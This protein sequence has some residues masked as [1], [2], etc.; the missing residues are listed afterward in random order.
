MQASFAPGRRCA[1]CR[2]CSQDTL[3]LATAF[4]QAAAVREFLDGMERRTR[5]E[6]VCGELLIFGENSNSPDTR[7]RLTP[8]DSGIR[9]LG[10]EFAGKLRSLAV[11]VAGLTSNLGVL[12]L[13][14][15]IFRQ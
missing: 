4:G 8:T 11:L 7:P 10:A 13:V 3:D 2:S 6:P 9:T 14:A 12:A 1:R 15:I 5:S